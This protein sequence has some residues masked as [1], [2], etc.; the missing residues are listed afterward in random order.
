MSEH[1]SQQDPQQLVKLLGEQR[2]LYLRL[3][4]L[5]EQQR[6]LIA[7]DHPEQLLNLLR[8]RQ[9]LVGALARLNDQLAPFR[10]NWEGMYAGLPDDLRDQANNLLLEINGLLRVILRSD[11]EDSAMLNARKETVGQRIRDLTGGQAANNA[12]GRRTDPAPSSSADMTG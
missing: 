3:R 10:K 6:A 1:I 9:T 2:D 7:S 8:E 4:D 12:Y 5:S 11:Q